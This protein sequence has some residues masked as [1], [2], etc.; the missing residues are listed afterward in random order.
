MVFGE[1]DGVH[2]EAVLVPLHLANVQRLLLCRA[3][4]ACDEKKWHVNKK[5]IT[6]NKAKKGVTRGNKY[7]MGKNCNKN[8]LKQQK[9]QNN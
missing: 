6:N 8:N 9:P 3:H 4:E 5:T 1:T 7:K 2:D